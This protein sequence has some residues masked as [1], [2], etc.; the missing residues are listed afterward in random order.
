MLT[1]KTI[2]KTLKSK[3]KKHTT[4]QQQC[5]GKLV[6]EPVK[7][8]TSTSGANATVSRFGHVYATGSAERA[9]AGRAS[10]SDRDGACRAVPT[11]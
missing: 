7:F 10:C 5:S 6:S 8:T 2:S 1:C 3:G 11:R 9:R 4:K